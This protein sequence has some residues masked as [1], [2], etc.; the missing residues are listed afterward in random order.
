MGGALEWGRRGRA[1]GSLLPGVLDLI[2]S[3]RGSHGRVPSRN[4][5][6]EFTFWK[7]PS[8]LVGEYPAWVEGG[9]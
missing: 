1:L 4:E 6:S 7:D 8:L 9:G 5:E 2:P 3:V